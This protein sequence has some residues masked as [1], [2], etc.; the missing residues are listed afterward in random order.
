MASRGKKSPLQEEN[1]AKSEFI[2]RFKANPFIFIGTVVILIIVIVAFVLVPAIVPE[3]QRG[4]ADLTFGFYNKVPINYVPGGYFAQVRENLAWYQQQQAS[5]NESNNQFVTYQIWRTAFEETVIHTGILQEMEAAGYTPSTEA[6]DREVA[7]LFQE[8]GRFSAARYQELDDN[9]RLTLWRQMRENIAEDYYKADITGLLK[10]AQERAFISRMA[11]PQRTFDMTVFSIDDYPDSE[12]IAYAEENSGLFQVTHLSKITVNSG[13]R[14]AR[15]ILDS[16]KEGTTTFEDAAKTQSQDSYAEKGGDMGIKSAYELTVEAPVAE[17]REKLFALRRGEYSDLIK[18]D[19]GWA[20]FRAEEAAVPMDI[21]DSAALE[22]VRSYIREFER[23]RMEDWTIAKA[24]EF[25]AQAVERGFDGAVIEQSL[26]KRHFGPIP[27]NY[28]EV[29]LFTT[30]SS[31]PVGEISGA[32][33]D[34]NFWRIAFSTPLNTPSA[35]LVLGNN[36]LVLFPLEESDADESASQNIESLLS[37]YWLSY[38][39][40]QNIRSFFLNNKKLENQFDKTFFR[41]FWSQE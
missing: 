40:E 14:E 30:L 7:Q 33:L 1:S 19:S 17:D 25:I 38:N 34:E 37:S 3:A 10:P 5:I 18:L 20:F 12:V 23:G 9:T 41:Y 31:I 28:G 36:V 29:D 39:A 4:G 2:R 27:V 26:E 21:G 13:E 11:S 15:Q 8:N 35:P 24:E 32:A 16:I 22:K 6:V